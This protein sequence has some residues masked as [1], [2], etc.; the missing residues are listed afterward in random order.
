MIR[1]WKAN[2]AI[3]KHLG[4]SGDLP[5]YVADP[6]LDKLARD[7]PEDYLEKLSAWGRLLSN[8]LYYRATQDGI[9]IAASFAFDG[10]VEIRTFVCERDDVGLR[11]MSVRSGID[12]DGWNSVKTGNRRKS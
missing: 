4:I 11:I 8:Q 1:I 2:L 6:D 9:D 3:K 7:Y 12:G 10:R 5:I